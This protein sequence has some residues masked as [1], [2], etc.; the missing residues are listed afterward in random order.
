MR[1]LTAEEWVVVSG[2]HPSEQ[3][4]GLQEVTVNGQRHSYRDPFSVVPWILFAQYWAHVPY[5]MRP[6]GYYEDQG[7]GDSDDEE[8][9]T[10]RDTPCVTDKPTGVA[11]T[12]LHKAAIE[13]KRA[14]VNPGN[15]YYEHAGL[16]Y[17]VP[18]EDGVRWTFPVHNGSERGVSLAG[19]VAQLI[20]GVVIVGMYHSQPPRDGDVSSIMSPNDWAEW[21][22]IFDN[23]S[24]PTFT[25]S[26]GLV[27][28]MGKGITADPNGLS[29][30]YDKNT[31]NIHVYDRSDKG[32][33]KQQCHVNNRG[34]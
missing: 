9:E 18:G 34:G 14:E 21:S 25:V 15:S 10:P 28:H 2:G 20:P 29:Y 7:G 8:Q 4:G 23:P 5:C 1:N 32:S 30:I 24:N 31:G 27:S 3:D 6:A 22:N 33:Y 19:A 17:R 11:L 26:S 13:L 12:D 16:I